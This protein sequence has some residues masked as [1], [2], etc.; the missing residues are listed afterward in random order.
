M[1]VRGD[2]AQ[3]IAAQVE[4]QAVEVVAHV[5]LGHRERSPLD[6]FLQGCFAD[7]HALGGFHFVHRR[8]VVGG[9]GGQGEAAAAGLH[10]DLVTGLRDGNPA[11]VG[12]GADDLEQ[13]AGGNGGFAVL[14]IFN[15]DPRHHLHFQVGTGQRQLA[16]LHLDQEIGQNR[17]GLAAFD[18]VD[19]L[20]QR[21]EKGFALQCETHVV[22]CPYALKNVE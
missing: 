15:R 19:D 18:H 1:A 6:Q 11:A 8:E 5:L 2:R 20:C 14:G 10:G 16:V 22:P 4:Q 17:K 13:L 9:Q 7:G 3:R 12:Q 21:L